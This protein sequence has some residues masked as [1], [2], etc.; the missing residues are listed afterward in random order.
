MILDEARAVEPE[1]ESPSEAQDAPAPAPIDAESFAADWRACIL[2]GEVRSTSALCDIISFLAHAGWWGEL[3]VDDCDGTTTRSLYFD[4]GHV[5]AA[6][7]TAEVE[8]LGAVLCRCDALTEEQALAASELAKDRGIRFGEA[9]VEL[10][11]LSRE[12]LFSLMRKQVESIFAGIVAVE[13]GKF[14]FYD[15]FDDADLSYRS[16]QSVDGL[17][18]G[19]ISKLDEERHFRGVVPSAHHVP[20]RGSNAPPLSEDPFGVYAAIDGTRTVAEVAA[21]IGIAELDVTRALFHQ[22]VAGHASMRPPRL[23]LRQTVEVYNDAIVVLLRELDAM[24]QGDDVRAALAKFASS[25]GEDGTFAPV[26]PADDGTLDID[27]TIAKIAR[28]SDPK[29]AEERLAAWLYDYASY[30]VFLAR[31]HLDRRDIGAG[32]SGRVSRRVADLLDPIAP[33]GDQTVMPPRQHIP[34]PKLKDPPRTTVP[35][36]AM[37]GEIPD[38]VVP[39]RPARPAGASTLHLRKASSAAVIPRIDPAR[40]ARMESVNLEDLEARR[41]KKLRALGASRSGSTPSVA[42]AASAAPAAPAASRRGHPAVRLPGAVAAAAAFPSSQSTLSSP[43]PSGGAL[44][45]AIRTPMVV[46]VA[47]ASVIIGVLIGHRSGVVSHG[48]TSTDEGRASSMETGRVVAKTS[49]SGESGELVV[50]CEPECGSVYVDG[51]RVS[52]PHEPIVTTSGEHDVV[53]MRP[54]YVQQT[55]RVSVAPGQSLAVAF[56][57]ARPTR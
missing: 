32:A 24:D 4:E 57:L 49:G 38:L 27:E 13:H 29:R 52:A 56:Q 48:D 41:T 9:V 23:P 55:R 50:A 42:P 54:G 22:V 45:A 8:R 51:K 37:R 43:T 34:I 3:V 39:S 36:S 16:K 44:P 14:L 19:A 28:A 31:P 6:Q 47:V 53:I 1:G 17:L 33:R 46:V 15:G 12:K 10:E 30:A 2:T 7:S 20:V 40:T 35:V 21:S 18:L 26:I 5:V 11:L 25:E